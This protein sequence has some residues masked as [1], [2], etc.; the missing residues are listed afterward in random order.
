MTASRTCSRQ[1]V[2]SVYLPA[3]AWRESASLL[4]FDLLDAEEFEPVERMEQHRPLVRPCLRQHL[5]RPCSQGGRGATPF[6]RGV[7]TRQP[8]LLEPVAEHA[9][10]PARQLPQGPIEVGDEVVEP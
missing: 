9:L 6:R 7:V 8:D 5:F 10:R 3:E 2:Y 1:D 4:N